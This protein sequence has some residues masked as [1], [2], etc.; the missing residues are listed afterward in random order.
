MTIDEPAV[1]KQGVTALLTHTLERLAQQYRSAAAPA[2]MPNDA[3]PSGEAQSHPKG[4]TTLG[5]LIDILDERAFGLMLL[6]LA[7]PCCIPFLWGIPQIVAL[8]MLALAA[9][10]A[11]GRERPWLPPKLNDREIDIAAMQGVVNRASRYLGWLERLASP[12]LQGLTDGRGAQIVGA[13]LLIPTAS[14]LVPLPSTNT[15][16][17]IGVAIAAVGFLERDGLLV[18]GGLLFGLAWVVFLVTAVAILGPEA[19]SQIKDLVLG[20]V[21]R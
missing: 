12:R 6:I 14:I 4:V 20:L 1:A 7:L 13:L 3:T 8:P 10:L 15:A 9:Q 2:A 5:K 19:I 17:G 18:L 21:G 16:P 11:L